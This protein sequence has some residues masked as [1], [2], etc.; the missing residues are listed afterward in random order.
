LAI[1]GST[2]FIQNFH[3]RLILKW[4]HFVCL[5]NHHSIT[6]TAKRLTTTCNESNAFY[7]LCSFPFEMLCFSWAVLPTL[8][9]IPLCFKCCIYYISPK[10]CLKS[11]LYYFP[12]IFFL[13]NFSWVGTIWNY[14][15]TRCN[16]YARLHIME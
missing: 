1:A 10:K 11:F 8:C 2:H 9:F 12:L 13:Y 6:H 4:P 3:E 14:S 7:S 16:I 15:W 5:F